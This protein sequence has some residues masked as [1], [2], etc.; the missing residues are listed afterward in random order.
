MANKTSKWT[1]K[2]IIGVIVAIVVYGVYLLY[3]K[4]YFVGK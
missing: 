2:I 1:V 3:W 4:M